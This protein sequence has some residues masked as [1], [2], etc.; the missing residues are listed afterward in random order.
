MATWLEFFVASCDHS[1]TSL[2]PVL[3]LI[4]CPTQQQ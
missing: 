3:V 1:M 4:V 2:Y